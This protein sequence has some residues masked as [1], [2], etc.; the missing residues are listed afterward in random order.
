MT[1]CVECGSGNRMGMGWR[2]WELGATSGTN[3]WTQNY[4]ARHFKVEVKAEIEENPDR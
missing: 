3:P 4:H 2:G 1:A